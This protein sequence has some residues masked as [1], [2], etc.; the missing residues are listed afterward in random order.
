[1]Q[2]QRDRDRAVA[3]LL[4][5]VGAAAD[6]HRHRRRPE[7]RRRRAPAQ[8]LV[9]LAFVA[10]AACVDGRPLPGLVRAGRRALDPVEK[11]M[12][13]PPAALADI[14]AVRLEL[15]Q[16]RQHDRAGLVVPADRA[17]VQTEMLLVDTG[18]RLE[19]R[20][21]LELGALDRCGEQRSGFLE[22]AG[23]DERRAQGAEQ[24]RARR[25]VLIEQSR[26]ALEQPC[27]RCRVAAHEG[28]SRGRAQPVHRLGRQR[29]VAL[30]G[31]ADLAAQ[32]ERL[33][34]VVA[35][36]LVPDGDW[37]SASRRP[38]RA[39]R[40]A[41][42][43]AC[44]SRRPRG[45]G[46]E[47]SGTHRRRRTRTGPGGSAACAPMRP[48]RR[49]PRR[50]PRRASA[51]RALRGG[52]AALDRRVH[53]H[54]ALGRREAIDARRQ[55]RL[56]ARRQRHEPLLARDGHE[57]L[58]KQRVAL[59]GRDDPAVARDP[60][61]SCPTSPRSPA[62]RRRTA[63][64][65]RAAAAGCG[66]AQAGRLSSS[67]GRA[68]QSSRIGAPL[69]NATTYSIRSSSVGSAQWTSSTIRTSGRSRA[70]RLEQP[71]H[72]PEGL[73]RLRR[74]AATPIAPSTW[75][76]ISRPRPRSR[77]APR[78]LA[79]LAARELLDDLGERAVG[80]P[81]AVGKAATD[82][83]G[84]LAGDVGDELAR[85]AGLPDPRRPHDGDRRQLRSRLTAPKSSRSVARSRSRPTNGVA[86]GG[87]SPERKP[88][89]PERAARPEAPACGGRLH[90]VDLDVL[91]DQP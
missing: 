13:L 32:P 4:A 71:A 52:S 1:M 74:P 80:D 20:V 62:P 58:E 45:S 42:A 65:A 40:P 31:G 87:D 68:R 34:E 39:G 8:D 22:A 47:R 51:R 54:R 2:G 43:W 33:L 38:A 27:A 12:Q 10:G 19:A 82:G 5:D 14:V 85:E 6:R 75:R 23:L 70:D 3:D 57:L 49:R 88:D 64:R 90:G 50:A 73:D 77:A 46:H 91:R 66:A 48:A 30:G 21:P 28:G 36:R 67:S 53:Q 24:F 16:C 81:V 72:R 83:D 26:G 84:G 18:T 41:R 59:G 86:G 15:P 61:S 55:H 76:A 60:G 89:E 7:D 25:I 35:E 11:R 63:P 17:L 37:S 56:D 9:E 44:R 29:A 78:A 79:P 69:E